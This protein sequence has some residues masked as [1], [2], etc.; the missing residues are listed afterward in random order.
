MLL[1]L[2]IRFQLLQRAL[3][4]LN[5]ATMFQLIGVQMI[6]VSLNLDTLMLH[7]LYLM[8]LVMQI[9]IVI[10]ISMMF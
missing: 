1:Q 3:T 9:L 8:H 4:I 7:A 6:M 10:L 2:Q 5:I